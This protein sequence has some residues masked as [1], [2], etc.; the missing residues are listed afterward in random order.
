M[1][2]EEGEGE[3]YRGREAGWREEGGEIRRRDV[4][5]SSTV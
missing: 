5:V 2:R 3:E 1:R 4:F